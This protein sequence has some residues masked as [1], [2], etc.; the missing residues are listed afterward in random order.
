M[1]RQ[2]RKSSPRIGVRQGGGPPPGYQWNVLLLEQVHGEA[3]EFLNDDQY[4]HLALQVKE[5]ARQDDPTHSQTIDVRA[6][7]DFHELRDKGGILRRLNVRIYYFV[8]TPGRAIVILG[9][10]KKEADGATPLH[11]KILMRN[12][13]R[14][15]LT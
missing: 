11:D 7:E 14:K 13:K 1:A 10:T 2:P 15:F 5:L 3:K 9:V 4:A 12:R 8:H 6:I